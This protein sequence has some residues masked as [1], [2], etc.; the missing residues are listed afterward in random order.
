MG[1]MNP[2]SYI[3]NVLYEIQQEGNQKVFYYNGYKCLIRRVMQKGMGYLCG[4]VGIHPA[5][6]LFMLPP[7]MWPQ[8]VKAHGGINW[9]GEWPDQKDGIRYIGFD[10]GHA[11]DMKPFMFVHYPEIS[12]INDQYLFQ[13]IYR[14]MNYVTSVI[15]LMVDQIITLEEN[16]KR[17]MDEKVLKN[18]GENSQT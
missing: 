12:K 11:G 13:E 14:D 10:C 7:K 3:K 6:S 8:L 4:Y 5:H 9:V 2:K 18:E 17:V 1:S 16:A 15:K